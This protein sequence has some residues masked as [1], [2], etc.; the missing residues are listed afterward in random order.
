VDSSI[1]T[2]LQDAYARADRIALQREELHPEADVVRGEIR[3]LGRDWLI[4]E[5]YD[6]AVY[7]DGWDLLRVADV[8][9]VEP[10]TPDFMRYVRRAEAELP[11]TP[12]IP[13]QL[14]EAI[15]APATDVPRMVVERSTLVGIYAES[16]EGPDV[17]F[18][19]RAAP[20]PEDEEDVEAND[21]VIREISPSGTWDEEVSIFG[22]DE[23]TRLTVGGRYQDALEKFGDRPRD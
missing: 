13:L 6:D 18:I 15:G 8:T 22:A 4:V 21:V 23:V 14:L 17:L 9:A 10:E 7:F 5:K 20:A 11:E 19:G 12:A 3:A 2:K 1:R 16:A